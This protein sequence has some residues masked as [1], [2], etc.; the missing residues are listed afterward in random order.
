MPVQAP[1]VTPSPYAPGSRFTL[2]NLY[3]RVG[4]GL[5]RWRRI[6]QQRPSSRYAKVTEISAYLVPDRQ[7]NQVWE[8]YDPR[9]EVKKVFATEDEARL[10]CEK[11]YLN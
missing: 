6:W 5:D 7:G 11:H 3:H 4:Q 9:T 10:W 1:Q 8:V 2:A